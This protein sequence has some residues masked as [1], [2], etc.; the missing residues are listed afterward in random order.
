[1]ILQSKLF[2]DRHPEGLT[3]HLGAAKDTGNLF[4]PM[5]PLKALFILGAWP[6]MD[7]RAQ[8]KPI[9]IPKFI[10]FSKNGISFF[11]DDTNQFRQVENQ[12][13]TID[14]YDGQAH[15][16]FVDVLKNLLHLDKV[17]KL[18]FDKYIVQI[19]TKQGEVLYFKAK[20]PRAYWGEATTIE[21]EDIAELKKL[22]N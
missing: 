7:L 22:I 16:P 4:E 13:V 18:W 10:G 12:N 19:Y 6:P 21:G 8:K 1:M 5:D 9:E 3:A 14:A 11:A 15:R 17:S 2:K 20:A